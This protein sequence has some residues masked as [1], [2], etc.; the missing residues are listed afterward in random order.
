MP[1]NIGGLLWFIVEIPSPGPGAFIGTGLKSSNIPRQLR[2]GGKLLPILN[3][4]VQAEGETISPIVGMTFR[5][6]IWETA[7]GSAT[8]NG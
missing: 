3:S 2:S 8:R 5:E 1:I 6:L 7:A 4:F